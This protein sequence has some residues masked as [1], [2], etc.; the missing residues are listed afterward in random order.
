MR[1][2]N[3]AMVAADTTR[4]KYYIKELIKNKLLPNYVLLLLNRDHELLPGQKETKTENELVALLKSASIKFE[5]S[6]ND[7]IN[8]DEIIRV[9]ES[10]PEQ[11][12]IFSGYGGALLKEK[13][14]DTGKKFLHIHGG[15]LPNYKGSTTNYYSLIG[16]NTIG[17][18]A[19]FLTKE[20][21][22]GPILL[23]KK[24][25][26]PKDRTEIDHNS[27]SEARAKTL[28]ECLQNYVNSGTWKY[29]L[30][31]NYGGE[32]FYII[33]P[34]LKHLAILAKEQLQ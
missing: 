32:T 30:E 16:E 11:V 18:S 22:C 6:L 17:A 9:I 2:N 31:N 19:I 29:E 3:I 28:I 4:T 13:I 20:I 27:D 1:L 23:R 10:R 14:L 26:P 25:L 12:F 21:D 33:H 8:S 34:V 5:I 15:Y 7:N 24:F